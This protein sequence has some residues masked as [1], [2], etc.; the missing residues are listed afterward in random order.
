MNGIIRF[1]NQN[2][3]KIIIGLVAIALVIVFVQILNQIAK[4]Q[5]RKKEE[6]KIIL[7]EEE[8]NLPTKSIIGDS[9]VSLDVTKDNV[10]LIEEFIDK[11]NQADIKGAY[12]MLSDDTKYVFYA[13]EDEFKNGYYDV[14]FKE[15]RI[16]DIKNLSSDNKRYTYLVKFASDTLSTGD[17][18]NTSAYQDYVTIDQ[19]KETGKINLNNLIYVR[20]VEEENEFEGIKIKV[21]KQLIFKD[22]EKYEITIENYTDKRILIDTGKKTSTVYVLGSDGVKYNSYISEISSVQCE[23]A[24]YFYKNYTI[25]FNKVYTTG[26]KTKSVVFSD[27]VRDLETY[28][29]TPDE[30][31]ERVKISVSI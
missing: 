7:T 3:R 21:N 29:Q 15:K 10:E 16:S 13:N 9:N 1:W 2:R 31:K 24:P 20:E 19:N 5:N 4:D 27:I 6:N 28:K 14:F 12:D 26:V 30:V 23:I 25:K 8:K 17:V 11:C 22:N 18:S